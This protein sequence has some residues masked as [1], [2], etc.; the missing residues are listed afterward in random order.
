M[1]E[2]ILR[3]DAKDPVDV[4][5]YTLDWAAWLTARGG[6]TLS[7]AVLSGIS[8]PDDLLVQADGHPTVTTTATTATVWL[9]GGTARSDYRVG[10]TITTAGGRTARQTFVVPVR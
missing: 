4:A 2:L 1:S 6:D 7:T 9:S 3:F 8:G 10:I 5:P